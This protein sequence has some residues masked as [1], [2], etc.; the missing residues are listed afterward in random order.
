METIKIIAICVLAAC[1]Y[2]I[3][4]DQ[5]TAR[6]CVEYFT[7]GHPPIFGGINDPTLLALGWGVIATWWVGLPLG[8]I[9][10][11]VA[12]VGRSCRLSARQLMPPIAILLLSM[13]AI[14]VIAGVAGYLLSKAGFV[15]LIGPLA[16][17]LPADR[18]PLFLAD[19]WAHV[20]SYASG[21]LGGLAACII[22]LVRRMRR[23]QQQRLITSLAVPP[24]CR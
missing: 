1:L 4:H 18:H 5:I 24:S 12:R 20:A 3:V 13:A 9:L 11:L 22:I 8:I 23:V 15:W 10:A 6:I 16:T 14:A 21:I 17:K 19:L 2:G 7:V